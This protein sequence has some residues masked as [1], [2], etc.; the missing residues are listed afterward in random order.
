MQFASHPRRQSFAALLVGLAIGLL[1]GLFVGAQVHIGSDQWWSLAGSAAG[2][3][4]A[5]AGGVWLFHYQ[6]EVSG[7]ADRNRIVDQID[8]ALK[9]TATFKRIAGE[10]SV[11]YVDLQ[12][13]MWELASEYDSI[14]ETV[15]RLKHTSAEIA[16]AS[17]HLYEGPSGQ[18][19]AAAQSPSHDQIWLPAAQSDV[20]ELEASLQ[21]A[22]NALMS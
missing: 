7:R 14:Q 1:A 17:T 15:Q 16:R 18:I 20:E 12:T 11:R 2:A 6:Q 13:V 5:I 9:H 10:D 22:R 4:V 3:I 21:S 19:T 8:S